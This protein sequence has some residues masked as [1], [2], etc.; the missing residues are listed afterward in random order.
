M[1]RRRPH[2]T[3]PPT[4]PGGLNLEDPFVASLGLTQLS[5]GGMN[6]DFAAERPYQ[7]MGPPPIDRAETTEFIGTSAGRL[8][9][10]STKDKTQSF[11]IGLQVKLLG[12][13]TG[14]SSLIGLMYDTAGNA[15]YGD[16]ID[17]SGEAQKLRFA[18]NA[19]G[20]ALAIAATVSIST[21]QSDWIF[22]TFTPGYQALY[23]NGVLMAEGHDSGALSYTSTS[24]IVLG[25][26]LAD[27]RLPN[28]SV[29]TA[30]RADH[31]L[32]QAEMATTAA[33]PYRLARNLQRAPVR[34]PMAVGPT[35]TLAGVAGAFGL[36]G[37]A[38]RLA[39]SR[40]LSTLAAAFSLTGTSAIL[41]TARKLTAASSAFA[42]GGGASR[43]I[44]SRRLAATHG[45]FSLAGSDSALKVSRRIVAETVAFVMSAAPATFVYSP[46]PGGQGATYTLVGGTG[47]FLVTP[48]FARLLAARRLPGI[49]GSFVGSTNSARLLA[50]RRMVSS[51]GA[52]NVSAGPAKLLLA[53]RISASSIALSFS[54][55]P[56][57]LRAARRLTAVAGSFAIA[58]SAAAFNYSGSR[59]EPIDASLVPASRTVV[60]AGGTRVVVFGGGTRVV[61]FD[62]PS[63][64]KEL[65]VAN[66]AKPYFKDGKWFVDKDPDEI[67]YYVADVTQELTDRATTIT[68]VEV[69]VSGVTLIEGPSVQGSVIVVKLEDMDESDGGENFWTAR[70]TCSNTE[71]FDRTTWL[72]RVDN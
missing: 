2:L 19:N 24:V 26:G 47:A 53:R 16:Q 50:V 42:A 3:R 6:W 54:P 22:A 15:P 43:L 36:I 39:T 21:T 35:Y 57:G 70:V 9:P 33:N 30:L 64:E 31:V 71:R 5:Y 48:T 52:F 68:S 69:L 38:A 8:R 44:V 67:S 32:T 56:A 49:A 63:I 55:S 4:Q 13:S 51:T 40:R 10:A 37:L 12:S 20:A 58:G 45:D 66:A 25:N 29:K 23:L 59:G 65:S 28:A 60:F 46:K 17:L 1:A 18:Y 11:T 27:G 14:Y 41:K 7:L 34:R 62:V 72:N 61:V